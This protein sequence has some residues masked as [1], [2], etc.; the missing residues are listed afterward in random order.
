MDHVCNEKEAVS[1]VLSSSLIP[2]ELN[3]IQILEAFHV[4]E[5]AE[6]F[7]DFPKLPFNLSSPFVE[8][9]CV[10]VL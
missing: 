10:L 3:E 8:V 1:Q 2:T 9:L 6:N 4:L 7:V 5:C